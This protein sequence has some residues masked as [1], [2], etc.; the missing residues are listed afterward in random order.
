MRESLCNDGEDEDDILADIKVL[1]KMTPT[2]E[3][4]G[5]RDHVQDLEAKSADDEA[6]S[7][8]ESAAETRAFFRLSDGDQYSSLNWPEMLSSEDWDL[9]GD[10]RDFLENNPDAKAELEGCWEDEPFNSE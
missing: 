2:D 7:I 8:A 1:M 9:V 3:I 10:V 6:D 4:Q 5:F